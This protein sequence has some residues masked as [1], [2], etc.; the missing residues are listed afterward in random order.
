MALMGCLIVTR[1]GAVS[2]VHGSSVDAHD[3]RKCPVLANFERIV[4][5]AM[6]H[7]PLGHFQPCVGLV[8]QFDVIWILQLLQFYYIMLM[9][10]ARGH[11]SGNKKLRIKQGK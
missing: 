3:Y 7:D 2:S 9:W 6:Q 1:A 11:L 5:E 4:L 8:F 10:L